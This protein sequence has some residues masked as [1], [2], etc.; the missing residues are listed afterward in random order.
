MELAE[1]LVLKAGFEQVLKAELQVLVPFPGYVSLGF[2]YR[3]GHLHPLP[4]TLLFYP[5]R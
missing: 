2:L 4:S 5:S 1:Q 3:Q